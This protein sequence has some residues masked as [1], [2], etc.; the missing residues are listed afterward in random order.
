MK[1]DF[2][3]FGYDHERQLQEQWNNSPIRKLEMENLE[4]KRSIEETARQAA[5]PA[6]LAKERYDRALADA[7]RYADLD[8]NDA[9]MIENH[10]HL[11]W[12][13]ATPIYEAINWPSH[14]NVPPG[15]P[16]GV[17]LGEYIKKSYN[18]NAAGTRLLVEPEPLSGQ[19]APPVVDDKPVKH[20]LSDRLAKIIDET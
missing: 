14:P 16:K 15:W 10:R 20:F 18:L 8:L 4:L 3:P 7:K 13:D 17:D 9:E 5:E 19:A 11:A 2:S 1:K 6:R 12:Y